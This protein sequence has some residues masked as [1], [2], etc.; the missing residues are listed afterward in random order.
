MIIRKITENDVPFLAEIEEQCFADCRNE[1]TLRGEL[2]YDY[3][4]YYA[5]V[6][7]NKVVG[8]VSGNV[9]CGECDITRIAVEANFRRKGIAKALLDFLKNKTE[10][11]TLEVREGNFAAIA[12]YEKCGFKKDFVRKNYYKDP[13]ENAVLMSFEKERK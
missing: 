10:K 5:A 3:T 4:V 8:Y 11:I 2:K 6:E 7:D 13:I 1:N 9:I 12:L